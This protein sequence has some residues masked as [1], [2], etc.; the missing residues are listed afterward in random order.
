MAEARKLAGRVSA[1]SEVTPR[2]SFSLN[3]FLQEGERVNVFV[4]SCHTRRRLLTQTQTC[5]SFFSFFKFKPISVLTSSGRLSVPMEMRELYSCSRSCL[6]CRREVMKSSEIRVD[7][8]SGR[9]R[10][11]WH[12]LIHV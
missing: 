11:V 10:D 4:P 1:E 9:V 6:A 3:I 2:R 8:F 12:S 5:I 7:T